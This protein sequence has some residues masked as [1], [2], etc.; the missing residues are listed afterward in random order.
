MMTKHVKTFLAA[1]L[2]SSFS[3]AFPPVCAAGEDWDDEGE[4]EEAAGQKE[5][6]EKDFNVSQW[7]A[8]II[9]WGGYY[10]NQLMFAK[11]P[12]NTQEGE[13]DWKVTDYNKLRLDLAARPVRG[14]RL[15]VDV[16]FKTY[17]G[18]KS[19]TLPDL[20]PSKFDLELS[21]WEAAD[22]AS[23]KWNLENEF[24]LDNACMTL[25]VKMLRLK[26]GKQQV[27][28]GS[29]YF[30]NPTDLFNV[31][32]LLDPTYEK[33]GITAV[34]AQLFFAQEAQL[35]FYYFLENGF[36]ENLEKAG[37]Y[38]GGKF[39]LID[40]PSLAVRLRKS[41]FRWDVASTFIMKKDAR[42]VMTTYAPEIPP[43]IP[44]LIIADRLMGGFEFSGEIKGV[45]LRGEVAVNRIGDQERFIEVLGSIDY[46]FR[47]GIYVL[48]EYLYNS[49]GVSGSGNYTFDSWI[50]FLTQS[51][52]YQG[53]HY[54]AALIMVPVTR[55]HLELQLSGIVNA[56]DG[57]FV[58]NPWLNYRWGDYVTLSIYGV[59][60][61]G[62]DDTDEFPATGHGVFARLRFAYN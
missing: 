20:L 44:E 23:V 29:G 35:D 37:F 24:Y 30:W 48:A 34:K 39:G 16:V 58:L 49:R 14:F 1:L 57:S 13:S 8:S 18:Y 22:P 50:N 43:V 15:D 36:E 38:D 7:L 41:F 54:V 11:L 42:I 55:A 53:R 21:L 61:W 52:R 40:E 9:E 28:F 10:E 56:S 6:A 27:R 5:G 33:K 32:D 60:S 12:H 45:G 51:I 26:V 59:F 3:L 47:H 17:H 46:T 2:L 4:E 19:I 31:K 62:D 25:T